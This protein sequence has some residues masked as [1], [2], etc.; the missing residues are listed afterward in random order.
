MAAFHQR[1]MLRFLE[2]GVWQGSPAKLLTERASLVL[3]PNKVLV[4][5]DSSCH[6]LAGIDQHLITLQ[7]QGKEGTSAEDSG[8]QPGRSA[9]EASLL[10]LSVM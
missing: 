5:D 4:Y 2:C 8:V 1:H 6:S 7:E 3:H 9:H 10:R